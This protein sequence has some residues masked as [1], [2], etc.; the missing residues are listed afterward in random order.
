MMMLVPAILVASNLMQVSATICPPGH[1]EVRVS[2]DIQPPRIDDS[3]TNDQ[4]KLM[5]VKDSV[6]KDPRFVETVGLTAA[7]ISVDSEIRTKSSGT[8]KGP[9]CVSPSVISIKLSTAPNVYIDVSHGACRQN[10]A[11]GHEM[12]HVQIDHNL[13]DRFVPIFRSR[14][15]TM[16]DAIGTMPAASY[17]DS[18]TI[19]ERI[20][21]KINA[22]LS[23]TYDSMAIER[24][25]EHQQHDSPEEYRRVSTACPAV[26]VNP[27]SAAPRL[28]S[29][30]GSS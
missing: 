28:R 15:A 21:E 6:T 10:V 12:G 23:V 7:T 9:V 13:I 1:T 27:P 22:M 26:S 3:K 4:L 17:D 24:A 30:D 11:M 19:R 5:T 20:E 29:H 18:S 14:I 8:E 25:L 16:A 2:E